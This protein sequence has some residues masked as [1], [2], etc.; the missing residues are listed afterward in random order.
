MRLFLADNGGGFGFLIFVIIVIISIISNIVRKLKE[1]SQK[2]PPP[3]QQM[4]RP[5]PKPADR[6]ISLKDFLEELE[7]ESKPPPPP[8]RTTTAPPRPPMPPRPSAPAI[9]T[10]TARPTVP[11]PQTTPQT[12]APLRPA[13]RVRQPAVAKR[14]LEPAVARRQIDLAAIDEEQIEE[15]FEFESSFEKTKQRIVSPR[16]AQPAKTRNLHAG[17]YEIK[18]HELGIEV[19]LTPKTARRAIVM[20]EI[21]R[22]PVALRR[23]RR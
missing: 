14:H 13:P 17:A 1:S 2:P 5:G 8:P 15:K 3:P 11:P 21:L 18:K 10:A 16:L 7:G 23:G 9:P 6:S 4:Q 20:S 12:E 19:T 22:P